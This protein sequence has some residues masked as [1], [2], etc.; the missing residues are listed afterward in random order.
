MEFETRQVLSG[1]LNL[2]QSGRDELI[3]EYN[4]W[5]NGDYSR[6]VALAHRNKRILEVTLG[7]AG[8]ACACRGRSY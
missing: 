1:L 6:K 4:Q 7:P 5:A 8:G 3:A 2:N